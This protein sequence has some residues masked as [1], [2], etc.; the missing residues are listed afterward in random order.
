MECRQVSEDCDD[1]R[2]R[3]LMGGSVALAG[4]AAQARA[5][6][7]SG[8]AAG[9]AAA[10]PVVCLIR[11]QI[12]PYQRDA[13]RDYAQAWGEVIPRCGGALIGYFLPLEGTN[14]VAWA[15][16]GFDSLAS[17]EAYRRRLGSD[18]AAQD[19]FARARAKRFILR[20]ERSF[21]EGVSGTLGRPRT[22][23]ERR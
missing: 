8:M 16:I 10:T 7:G 5:A 20:E 17:Y 1:A 19:N 13:F 22:S 14:D 9:A 2:R 3:V 23:A 15:L 6:P 18:P 21:I 4:L 11:Y 12:D